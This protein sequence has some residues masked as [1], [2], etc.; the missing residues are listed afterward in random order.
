M[1]HVKT[2]LLKRLRKATDWLVSAVLFADSRMHRSSCLVA[3]GILKGWL[4][5]D[6]IDKWPVFA[7]CTEDAD[8]DPPA[9]AGEQ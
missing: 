5:L 9:D 6:E 2:E 4:D 7:D 3:H 8:G 1:A